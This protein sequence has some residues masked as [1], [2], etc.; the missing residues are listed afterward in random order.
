MLSLSSYKLRSLSTLLLC[1]V[2][3]EWGRSEAPGRGTTGLAGRQKLGAA[4]Y[5]F[6]DTVCF[7]QLTV[8]AEVHHISDEGI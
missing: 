3:V 1:T 5:C 7:E 4:T 2:D 6:W 8:K